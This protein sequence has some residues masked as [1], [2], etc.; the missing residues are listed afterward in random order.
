VWTWRDNR[1]RKERI[2]W[3]MKRVCTKEWHEMC[4]GIKKHE[5]T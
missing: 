4:E 5:T 3:V 2:K 1:V